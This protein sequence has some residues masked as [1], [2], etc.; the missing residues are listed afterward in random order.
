M[1]R[2]TARVPATTANLGSGFD[3]I[4]MAF[5]WYDE[6]TLVVDE[7]PGLVVE[8]T[9]EGAEDVPRDERHLVVDSILKG[10]AAFGADVPGMRLTAHNTIPHSRGLGSSAA[11]IVAGLAL[12][13]GI[14]YPGIPLD[15]AVLTRL[16]T[17]EEGHPDN[18]GAVAWGGAILAWSR[19]DKVSLVQL[20]LPPDFAAIAYV[21]DFECKTA[22]ARGVLPSTVSREDAVAQAITAAV[23]PLAL[24]RRPDL[25]F[26]ATRDRLHQEYRAPLMRPSYDLMLELRRHEVPATISGAGPTVLAVGL[27]EQLAPAA[28]VDAEGFRMRR[29]R[30]GH[31]AILVDE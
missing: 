26:D 11:A 29:L 4:G 3:C 8:V 22:E 25:L 9:G 28:Q 14:A 5:D 13:W 20:E 30:P 18:V 16:G 10:L 1:R 23:L 19:D 7:A 27:E 31:G 24:T 2:I 17:A 15:P 6:L 21:P 12:A